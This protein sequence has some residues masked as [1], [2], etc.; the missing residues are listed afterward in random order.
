MYDASEPA[1][2]KIRKV[3]RA[4]YGAAD[5]AFAPAAVV[6]SVLTLDSS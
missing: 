5:V 1:E 3:A 6:V 4:V 2:E